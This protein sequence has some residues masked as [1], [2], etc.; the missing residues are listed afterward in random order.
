MAVDVPILISLHKGI[1]LFKVSKLFSIDKARLAEIAHFPV[2]YK[3]AKGICIIAVLRSF[4]FIH[5]VFN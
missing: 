1:N 3:S 4:G 5:N 2:N